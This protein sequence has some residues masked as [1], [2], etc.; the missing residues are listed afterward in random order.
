MQ[1]GI[2]WM[3]GF[4][5]LLAHNSVSLAPFCSHLLATGNQQEDEGQRRCRQVHHQTPGRA[6]GNMPAVEILQEPNVMFFNHLDNPC[7]NLVVDFSRNASRTQASLWVGPRMCI[8]LL[9]SNLLTVA[10]H[11]GQQ[12]SHDPR[13]TC[14]P[15]LAG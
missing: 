2:F 9:V 8:V 12:V 10:H 11:V 1:G 6:S 4:P 15:G 3:G 14:L 5:F 7:A 13:K